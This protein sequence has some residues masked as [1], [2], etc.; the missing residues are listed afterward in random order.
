MTA[1]VMRNYRGETLRNLRDPCVSTANV[2]A[3]SV[4]RREAET[5]E[6]AQRTTRKSGRERLSPSGSGFRMPAE[7]ESH[8]ATWIAWPHNR[9]DWPGKFTTIPWVYGEIVR[10]LAPGEIVRII[11]DSDA[12]Q[13]RAR[14]V[15]SRVGADLARVEFFRFPTN[16]GWTRDFGPMFVRR[17]SKRPEV[18]IVRFRFNAWAKYDDWKK[19]DRV[20]E[21]AA[22]ALGCRIFRAQKNKRDV[23][24][25]GGAIDVNG[26]GTLIATEECLLDQAVQPRN[27]NLSR[28]DIESALC[29]NL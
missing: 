28:E 13:A 21:R 4:H 12:H 25:E 27:P 6:L 10:K 15:L 24:L 2:A 9:T 7:W 26:R 23:V 11:V 8:E 16:R 1:L 19:D 18:A 22:D 17:D 3:S 5:A 29:E 20:A 14:S